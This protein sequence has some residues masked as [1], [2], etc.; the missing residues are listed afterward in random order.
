MENKYY[1]PILEE[2]FVGFEYE[3]LTLKGDFKKRI[4]DAVNIEEIEAAIKLSKD[5]TKECRVKILDKSDIESLGFTHLGS[6]WFFKENC[7]TSNGVNN[8]KIRK[9]KN[10]EID[11]YID[12]ND[13][14]DL[15]LIFRGNIKNKSELIKLLTFLNIK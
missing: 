12:Y 10:N 4:C 6:L 3:Y 1:S 15:F 9:W 11:V 8:C 5:F 13:T 7:R 2:F 14:D